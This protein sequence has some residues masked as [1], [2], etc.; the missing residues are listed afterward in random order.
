MTFAANNISNKSIVPETSHP[1]GDLPDPVDKKIVSILYRGRIFVDGSNLQ[2]FPMELKAK[3]MRHLLDNYDGVRCA[4][5]MAQTSKYMFALLNTNLV[6]WPSKALNL[7]ATYCTLLLNG[8]GKLTPIVIELETLLIFLKKGAVLASEDLSLALSWAASIGRVDLIKAYVSITGVEGWELGVV[9]TA[10]RMGRLNV[11]DHVLQNSTVLQKLRNHAL[12]WA[13]YD[14][15][16]AVI[17]HLEKGAFTADE[18]SRAAELALTRGHQAVVQHL[19]Q[20]AA[21]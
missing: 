19:Q 21:S 15:Q 1:S 2:V 16:L 14:G 11:L 18:R 7:A 5:V 8:L 6:K 13:A 9:K 10:A 3:M 20:P 12:Q 4:L 17:Q